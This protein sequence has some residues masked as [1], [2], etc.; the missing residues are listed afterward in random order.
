[1]A[2]DLEKHPPRQVA[3]SRCGAEFTCTQSEACW[4]NEEAIRLPMPRGGEDC[5][6][7]D[8]LRKAAAQASQTP[9]A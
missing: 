9:Q 1:M 5:L 6:C 3:C 4:C 8:C 2:S 7:A